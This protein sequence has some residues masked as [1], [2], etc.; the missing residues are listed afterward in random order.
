MR[1][2]P[3][4]SPMVDNGSLSSATDTRRV[5]FPGLLA[6]AISS[7]RAVKGAATCPV[8]WMPPL[9]ASHVPDRSR[10]GAGADV[11]VGG[12]LNPALFHGFICALISTDVSTA[13]D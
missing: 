12:P 5:P 3:V 13:T 4:G 7:P 1:G 8:G 9:P 11:P 6:R 10:R 2:K